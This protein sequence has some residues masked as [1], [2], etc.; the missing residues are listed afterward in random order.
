MSRPTINRRNSCLLRIGS[1][2]FSFLLLSAGFVYEIVRKL[3]KIVD[4]ISCSAYNSK[5]HYKE[6][7]S[8]F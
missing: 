4:S 6:G 8:D 2:N 5:K 3:Y 1:S 7:I